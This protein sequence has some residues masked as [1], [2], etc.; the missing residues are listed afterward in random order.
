MHEG[1]VLVYVS[2][3]C[4][5]LYVMHSW[6]HH[7]LKAVTRQRSWQE[8][9]IMLHDVNLLLSGHARMYISR[10]CIHV[11]PGVSHYI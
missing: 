1:A 9:T 4:F 2:S 8:T 11:L 5:R 3:F 7:D 6:T 10:V